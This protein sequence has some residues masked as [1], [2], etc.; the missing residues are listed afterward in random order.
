M[1]A[2]GQALAANWTLVQTVPMWPWSRNS[3]C[4]RATD[5]EAMLAPPGGIVTVALS[6]GWLPR[7][8]PPK[9]RKAS[10]GLKARLAQLPT[11]KGEAVLNNAPPVPEICPS[12]D[13]CEQL[14]GLIV[15]SGRSI[16]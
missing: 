14:V 1:E 5:A 4:G 15:V 8:V 2:A 3:E 12:T 10:F 11:W 13:I 16:R 6:L 9:R 7:W